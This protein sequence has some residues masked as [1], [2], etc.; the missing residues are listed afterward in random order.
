LG[1]KKIAISKIMVEVQFHGFTFEKWV[2]DTFFDGYEGK[3]M[4]KWDIPPDK[5]SQLCIP[6]G[7]RNIPVSVK[8]AKYGSPIGLGDVRRQRSIDMPFVI[9]VGFWKQRT[10][11]EK[12]FEE[13]GVAL[14]TVPVWSGLWGALTI[15]EIS[16]I[17]SRI[18]DLT[19]PYA[20]A[21]QTAQSW[22]SSRV[23]QSGGEIVINPK[24][25]SKSQRRIQ[26]SIPF[27]TFWRVA[28]RLPLPTDSP[29]LFGVTFENPV[30]SGSRTFNRD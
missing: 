25:D 12:W 19:L 5:N 20:I 30:I 15:E 21:R 17:D 29:S 1:N 10:P 22:K 26:C 2:R 13:I 23:L 28:G 7:Y 3:Y 6:S 18:K 8:T 16:E 27:N 4:Q 24:I 9:I 14:F 11:S